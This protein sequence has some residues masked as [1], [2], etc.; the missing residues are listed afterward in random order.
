ME[1]DSKFQQILVNKLRYG[2][3]SEYAEASI[4]T[5]Q[6]DLIQGNGISEVLLMLFDASKDSGKK[7]EFID[8]VKK[9]LESI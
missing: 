1:N 8:E 7:D 5:I 2:V 4:Y 6:L 9:L 3:N